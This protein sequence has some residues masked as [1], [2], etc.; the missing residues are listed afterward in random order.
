MQSDSLIKGEGSVKSSGVLK[1]R[2]SVNIF[3]FETQFAY[4]E[5]SFCSHLV[6]L[7]GG[8]EGDNKSEAKAATPS[9]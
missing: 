9:W 4:E 8:I 5:L 2:Q 6:K 1:A 7:L 3:C